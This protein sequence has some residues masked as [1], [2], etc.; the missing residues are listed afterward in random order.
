MLKEDA[1]I[2]DT[3]NKLLHEKGSLVWRDLFIAHIMDYLNQSDCSRHLNL[4]SYKSTLLSPPIYICIKLTMTS[5]STLCEVQAIQGD[6]EVLI[7]V[8]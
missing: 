1:D 4:L 3:P 7:S 2:M 6:Q 5:N 8:L